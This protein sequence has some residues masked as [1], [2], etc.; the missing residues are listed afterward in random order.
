MAAR[1]AQHLGQQ[2]NPRNFLLMHA[3]GPNVA[4]VIGS[5]VVAG[6]SW[7]CWGSWPAGAWLAPVGQDHYLARVSLAGALGG[8][9][10]MVGER[11]VDD[12]PLIGRHRLQGEGR[13]PG[14]YLFRHA[15]RQGLERLG[16]TLLVA[17]D[18]NHDGGPG[19]ELV[20]DDETNKV[21]EGSQGLTA[22]AYQDAEVFALHIEANRERYGLF[23]VG[24]LEA[25]RRDGAVHLHQVQ[26]R[27]QDLAGYLLHVLFRLGS[28]WFGHVRFSC[29]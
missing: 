24:R 8:D 26:E 17:L 11:Q 19:L 1:V 27:L 10:G 5:A 4:G 21:L 18:V 29:G 14:P 15:Y 13:S 23:T 6:C 12:A 7:G 20:V 3:L 22:A 28:G 2:E 9:I 25:L 16:A